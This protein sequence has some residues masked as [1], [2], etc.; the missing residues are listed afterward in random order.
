MS[1]KWRGQNSSKSCQRSLWMPH[2]CHGTE[3]L[4]HRAA[5]AGN[6]TV[7]REL[8]IYGNREIKAKNYDGLSALH[9][10]VI[11]NETVIYFKVIRN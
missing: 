4:L 2:R 1:T 10:A 8:L 3:N 11:Q 7:V 9:L 6:A 5:I